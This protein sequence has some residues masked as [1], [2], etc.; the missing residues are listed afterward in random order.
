M[1]K[2]EKQEKIIERKRENHRN[3]KFTANTMLLNTY[4]SVT[5]LNVNELNSLLKRHKV[6]EWIKN[7]NPL[8]DVKNKPE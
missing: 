7:Q 4:L 1:G 8:M 2:K 5:T 6:S 3:T